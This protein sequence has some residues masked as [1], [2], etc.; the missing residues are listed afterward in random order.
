M[1]VC[2]TEIY[3][4]IREL[5]IEDFYTFV[6]GSKYHDIQILIR[7]KEED[8]FEIVFYNTGEGI[9]SGQVRKISNLSLDNLS[10]DFFKKL[11][12]IKL[13]SLKMDDFKQHIFNSLGESEMIGEGLWQK[14]NTCAYLSLESLVWDQLRTALGADEAKEQYKIFIALRNDVIVKKAAKESADDE[15]LILAQKKL[16]FQERYI[17][18]GRVEDIALAE[19]TFIKEIEKHASVSDEVIDKIKTARPIGKLN[20]L[21]HELERALKEKGLTQSEI[22]KILRDENIP[23]ILLPSYLKAKSYAEQIPRIV[24]RLEEH[25]K[26]TQSLAAGRASSGTWR[27]LETAGPITHTR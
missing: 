15:I 2:A 1:E 14:K 18:Y 21:H 17:L 7:K 26:A 19:E 11:I 25:Y 20:I 4:S 12:L 10:E 5:E 27:N 13:Q 3:D 8:N 23:V 24:T 9:G 6:S 22:E 16:G